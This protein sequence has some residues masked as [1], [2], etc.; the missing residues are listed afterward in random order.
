MSNW[1]KCSERLP[2]IGEKVIAY[3]CYPEFVENEEG[4]RSHV[5]AYDVDIGEGM[6][7]FVEAYAFGMGGFVTHWMPIPPAPPAEG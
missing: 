6:E 7:G 5:D 3:V 2:E 4:E 1:I